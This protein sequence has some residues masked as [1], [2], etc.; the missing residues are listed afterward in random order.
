MKNPVKMSEAI[1]KQIRAG[2]G[3]LFRKQNGTTEVLIIRR[4]GLWDL[5]KG[6][7]DSGET[8]EECAKREISEELG[9]SEP[10]I[11]G[12]LC[13]TWHRYSENGTHFRKQTSWFAM[14]PAEGTENSIRVQKEEGITDHRW[15]PVNE[16]KHLVHFD[17]LKTVL[18]KFTEFDGSR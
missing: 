11:T 18:L 5:P 8:I 10:R 3:V 6:K 7:L 15:V 13:D 12:F 1:E 4:N 2:G 17:N 14:V 16:A 9:I